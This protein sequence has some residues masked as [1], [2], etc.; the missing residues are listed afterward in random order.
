[1]EELGSA[2]HMWLLKLRHSVRE[3]PGATLLLSKHLKADAH[4]GGLTVS[5]NNLLKEKASKT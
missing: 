3:W 5:I 2:P 4:F 1:M